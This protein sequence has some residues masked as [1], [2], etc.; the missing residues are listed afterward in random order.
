MHPWKAWG[1]MKPMFVRA[2]L[3]GLL[4]CVFSVHA[5]RAAIVVPRLQDAGLPYAHVLSNALASAG[6]SITWQDYNGIAATTTNTLDN[7]DLLVIPD[8]RRLPGTSIGVI[9]RHLRR[10]GPIMAM[11]LPLWEDA[12][13]WLEGQWISRR[14]Y[15]KRVHATKPENVFLSYKPGDAVQ[16]KHH[17]NKPES[18]ARLL[19]AQSEGITVMHATIG[20]MT[21]WDN[22]EPPSFS[23]PFTNHHSLTCF[24]AKG[25]PRTSQLAV[26]WVEQ[27]GSRWIATVPL[28]TEWC[29]YALAPE[30]FHYWESTAGRGGKGD[31]LHVEKANRFT[32]GLAY[33]H[34]TAEGGQHEFWLGSLGTARNPLGDTAPPAKT[35]LPHLETLCPSY[36]FYPMQEVQSITM[37]EGLPYCLSGGLAMDG[38]LWGMH[39]RP[40]GVGFN[41]SRPWRWQPLLAALGPKGDYRGALAS[42]TLHS[43]GTYPWG[44]W[45]AFTPPASQWVQQPWASKLL[46]QVANT[47]HGGCLLFE[48]GAE[49]FTV[50]E[51]QTIPMGFRVANTRHQPSNPLDVNIKVLE[52]AAPHRAAFNNTWNVGSLPSTN[53]ISISTNWTPQQ[54]PKGGYQIFVTL[55]ENGRVIDQLSHEI[56][57]WK[58]HAR[59]QFVE[60]RDGGFWLKN[61]PWKPHGVNYMPSSGIGV[62]NEYFEHWVGRGAYDP[63]VIER[64]LRRIAAMNLN[65]V[66]V[67]IY[68]RSLDAQHLLDFLHRCDRLG[69]KVNQSL[70]PGTPL[71]FRWQEMKAL[72][73][74]Y[75]L[76][77]N[78]AVFAYDL[79]WEPSHFDHKHQQG[80]SEA[81]RTWV[82]RKY[83]SVA[84]AEKHWCMSLS[85]TNNEVSVPP[86]EY[87]CQDGPWRVLTADYRAFLDELLHAPYAEARR[88]VQSIDPHHPVSFRMQ[89]SGDPTHIWPGLLPYDFRG[90]AGAVDI[91]EP[92]A[93]G[94]IGNWERVKPGCFTTA[95]AR[96]CDPARPVMWAEMGVSVLN[97]RGFEPSRDQLAFAGRYY[98]DFYKMLIQSG[99]DGV[100]FWWYPGGYR[101]GENS[102]YG[103]INPDGT[104]R[105][106][107]QVIRKNGPRFLRADKPSG[108]IVWLQ[109]DRDADARGLSGIYET[110]KTAYWQAME[111]GKQPRLRWKQQPANSTVRKP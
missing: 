19:E 83:G 105:T 98:Q 38:A 91:W 33:S 111:A 104:D 44:L 14:E 23:N 69:I 55:L 61:R 29:D 89:M 48:G 67:F 31:S 81:W 92:E 103:I 75:R 96:L 35:P 77:E 20:N 73:E 26:E 1:P 10:G 25:G 27:D 101:L 6:Y 84:D 66:S 109:V 46:V 68:Y 43:Q 36:L 95:Y 99:S 28:T 60:A 2:G 110:T 24:R 57:V 12:V 9:E 79:A 102:D 40:R 108:D 87:L 82:A 49:Y 107:T 11:G 45:T 58:P 54:W 42:M 47:M 41:Q 88:L 22:W 3:L 15:E 8:G 80:Y 13:Y 78:D 7:E 17:T 51:N 50:F 34:G 97:T 4:F 52:T 100:F 94:R 93:Y 62:A 70:R 85:S 56:N 72:I 5:E 106:I 71:D 30:E 65:A 64:D 18:P 90:L 74:H 39:P 32:V 21:G 63:E 76:A 53:S 59:P 37:V 86:V 16:W